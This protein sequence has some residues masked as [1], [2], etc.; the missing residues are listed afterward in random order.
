MT[1]SGHVRGRATI[2][3]DAEGDARLRLSP[4]A[5]ELHLDGTAA[6]GAVARGEARVGVDMLGIAIRQGGRAEGWAGAGARGVVGVRR[7]PDK[8]TWRFGWGAALG[9][10]GAAEWYGSIDVS[11]V[12]RQHRSVAR[13]SLATALRMSPFPFPTIPLS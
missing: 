4:Q 6:A 11:R 1:L 10:G 9:L 8:V 12:P 3:A 2:G 13:A 5:Q 7:E